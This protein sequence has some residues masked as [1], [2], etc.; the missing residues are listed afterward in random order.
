MPKRATMPTATAEFKQPKELNRFVD[1]SIP[2]TWSFRW[3]S[4]KRI[5]PFL[6]FCS[7]LSLEA[8]G[9]GW[10]KNPTSETPILSRLL[11]GGICPLIFLPLMIEVTIRMSH[12]T[13]R[14]L[15]IDRKGLLLRHSKAYRIHWNCLKEITLEPI[16][17]MPP[18]AKLE[19]HYGLSRKSKVLKKWSMVLHRTNDV[20]LLA[21]ALKNLSTNPILVQQLEHAR[22]GER[23][24]AAPNFAVYLLGTFLLL[25]GLPLIATGWPGRRHDA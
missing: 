16:A 17:E 11:V 25:H 13:E 7:V 22:P 10:L 14:I 9:L 3:R 8:V 12:L 2:L 20:P 5:I 1:D 21:V 4:F 24:R 18:Y 23:P 19:I 6:V 15:K